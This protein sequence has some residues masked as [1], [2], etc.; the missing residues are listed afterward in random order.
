MMT[1]SDSKFMPDA[2]RGPERLNK[3][4][5]CITLERGALRAAL[6]R[7]AGDCEFFSQFV[8][9]RAHLFSNAPV[10]IAQSDIA[11]M[12]RIVRAPRWPERSPR[13]D[14]SRAHGA[15]EAVR[16]LSRK[17]WRFTLD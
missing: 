2:E 8:K 9:T 15:E 12:L 5:F 13:L 6:N 16:L 17:P 11:A 10:F 14:K 7:E 3:E 1:L 4:C